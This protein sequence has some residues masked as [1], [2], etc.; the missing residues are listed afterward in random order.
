MEIEKYL[1]HQ[2]SKFKI[3]EFKTD[4]T[5]KFNSKNEAAEILEENV[6]KMSEL[7]DK[8]YA[9]DKYSL[10]LIFQAMDAAG[11]D[12]TIKHVMSG[13]NPQGTQVYSFKQPSAEEIDHGYLWR[14]SKALPE[15]GRIGIFNRSHYEEV[16]IVRVHNLIASSKLPE[17][18]IDKNIWQRRFEHITNF[19]K[20][21]YE[22]GTVILKFFLHISKEEQKKRFLERIDNPAKNWKF[23]MGDIEERK[24]WDEYQKCYEEA[25][26]ATSK[27]C[28]PWFIIPAD[29]K[30]FARLLVS[31]I[32]VETL[33]K[34]KPEYPELTDEQNKEILN[35]KNILT[36]EKN[37]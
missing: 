32:I 16:L 5:D 24:Y 7:Q 26:A 11:K 6:K 35:A 14:I 2:H 9:Q 10:L 17:K 23:A 18:F 1:A 22:N 4:D 29:K 27:D 3:S 15:R 25:I 20:Y 36:G 28:S 30:W 12:G 19:E 13:L 33:K 31:E 37:N 34:L 21:L 8:L